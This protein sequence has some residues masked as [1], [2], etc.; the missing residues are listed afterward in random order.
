MKSLCKP[1][2]ILLMLVCIGCSDDEGTPAPQLSSEKELLSFQ[3]L[4]K[5]N[6]ITYN[7]IGEIDSV[8]QSVLIVLPGST[9]KSSLVPHIVVSE[10]ATVDLL[11]AY[12]FN[13][14]V[15]FTVTAED[16]ST[17]DYEVTVVNE[18]E[19][20]MKLAETSLLTP[21][22]FTINNLDEWEGVST[23]NGSVTG[24]HLSEVL[25][26]EI[27][28]EITYLKNLESLVL[29]DNPLTELPEEIGKLQNLRSVTIALNEN[30]NK[31]PA[32]IG[33]LKNL[34]RLA[35]FG[36]P[37]LTELPIEITQLTK[38]YYLGLYNNA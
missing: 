20:L 10:G 4:I 14:A 38:L 7:T 21:W 22:H 19:A 1:L 28:P 37:D 33:Q 31:I 32:S 25:C 9:L 35:I 26:Y 36:S 3:F 27:P 29:I 23:N 2:P 34:Q 11:G 8:D 5:D 17:K 24:L 30:L 13:S 6:P 12:N 15:S 16:G 18:K